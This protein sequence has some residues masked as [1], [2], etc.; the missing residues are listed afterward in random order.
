MIRRHVVELN[1]DERNALEGIVKQ[2]RAAAQRRRHAGILL[3]VDQGEHGPS[4]SDSEAAEQ[5][6]ITARSVAMIRKRCVDEGLELAL[7]RKKRVR[8][9]DRRL[10]GDGEARLVSLACSEAPE[11]HARWTLKLLANQLV[12]LEVV[13]S[14]ATE[15]VRQVLKKHHKTLAKANVVYRAQGKRRFRLPDGSRA[16][17][18]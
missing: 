5:M 2:G 8:E 10:D 3:L 4:M 14:I 12:E 1:E 18:I 7:E 9:R 15:T 13:S 17:R 11:G 16:G 6:G